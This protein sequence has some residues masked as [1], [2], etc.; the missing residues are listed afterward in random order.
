MKIAVIIFWFWKILV[1]DEM[2]RDQDTF[3]ER[4]TIFCVFPATYS[5]CFT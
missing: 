1:T 3:F 2:E 4:R 5:L